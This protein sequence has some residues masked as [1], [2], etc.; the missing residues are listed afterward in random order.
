MLNFGFILAY[1]KNFKKNCLQSLFPVAKVPNYVGII[2]VTHAAYQDIGVDTK[3][4]RP[5]KNTHV[6]LVTFLVNQK[7]L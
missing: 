5:S 6:A 4:T 1:L 7:T 3:L 2:R